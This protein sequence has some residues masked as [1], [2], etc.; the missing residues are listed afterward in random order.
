MRYDV[1]GLVAGW[2]L[3]LLTIPLTISAII[4]FIMGDES[5]IVMWSFTPPIAFCAVAGGILVKLGSRR[6]SAERLR[7]R[8]AVA[9][10]ALSWPCLLY[11]S[12]SPRD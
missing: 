7:D 4:G 2:S 11:T 8:E 12:P 6:D 1:I 3:I 10:V 5:I 9:A